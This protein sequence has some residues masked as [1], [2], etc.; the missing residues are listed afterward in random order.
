MRRRDFVSLVAGASVAWPLTARAQQP[1]RPQRIGLLATAPLQPIESFRKRLNDLGHVEGRNVAVEARF[2][3]GDDAR[4]P[5]M[6]AELA[7]L[8]VDMIVAWGTPAAFAAKRA[9]ATI[10]IVFVAGDVLNT[11]LV[12]NLARPEANITGFSALNAELEEKRIE[13][14]KEINPAWSRVAVLGNALNPLHRVNLAAARRAAQKLGMTLDVFE[15]R[16][17]AEIE[18]ALR[19]LVAA[20][21]DAVVIGSD[22]TLMTE[23]RRIA[24]TMRDNKLP[25]VYPFREYI[26]AGAFIIY[27]ANISL[28][29]QKAA[30]Y[31]DRILKGETPAVLPVQQATT[32]EII[33]NQK[34]AAALGLTLPGTVLVRADDV[35]E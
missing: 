13:L 6:A 24:E 15:V 18:P 7:G 10:P 32:V 27:A 25:A 23:R 31:A 9:T 17:S 4:Y 20:R 29:F 8:P 1:S 30:E 12:S 33:I 28:L 19:R 3:A 21:P 16:D 5:A 34:V 35:I 22:T 14:L 2:V 11:G 26:E